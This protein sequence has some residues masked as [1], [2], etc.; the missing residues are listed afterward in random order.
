MKKFLTWF[1]ALIALAVLAITTLDVGTGFIADKGARYIAQTYNVGV[2]IDRVAGNP[3]RGYTL[4]NLKLL[5]NGRPLLE[6]GQIFVDPSLLKLLRGITALDWVELT[7][8]RSTIPDLVQLGEI[9]TG[10]KFEIPEGLPLD[11]LIL[12]KVGGTLDGNS[13]EAAFDIIIS[14]LPVKA[15]FKAD[16][17][18]EIKITDGIVE[19]CRGTIALSGNVTPIPDL[20]LAVSK[21]HLEDLVSVVPQ[22]KELAVRGAVNSAITLQG[23]SAL[24]IKGSVELSDGSIMALPISAKTNIDFDNM[25][26]TLSPLSVSAIGIPARGDAY[27]NLK[28]EIPS[29][30]INI[31][32]E[33]PVTAKVLRH[34][35]PSLPADLSGGVERA[36]VSITGPVTALSGNVTLEAR[37]LTMAGASL[38]NTRLHADA[39]QNGTV[40]IKG[41]TDL[42]GNPVKVSGTITTNTPKVKTVVAIN[43]PVFDLSL[44]PAIIS[45]APENLRG[46]VKSYAK[47]TGTGSDISAKIHMT[48]PKVSL[49]GMSV[50][51]ID[52]PLTWK[53]KDR[54][55]VV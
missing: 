1:V 34:N 45:D 26:L 32:T 22:I 14:G 37:K 55:S 38:D 19:T 15:T 52:L 46:K 43:A 36:S 12:N 44:L 16:V 39:S 47:I 6:A 9:F 48:S 49:N 23:S 33:A 24:K 5:R 35:L 25:D 53:N 30:R 31:S 13:A 4:D 8:I 3:V 11:S 21:L 27:I 2:S 7:D 20:R 10:E 51:K 40:K 28:K 50:E 42:A 17:T 54:K 18:P 41:R 29:V